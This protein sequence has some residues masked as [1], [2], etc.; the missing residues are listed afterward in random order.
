M[1]PV[2]PRAGQLQRAS[3][4]IERKL[5]RL[6]LACTVPA[7]LALLVLMLLQYR[8][9]VDS[10]RQRALGL[11]VTMSAALDS[12]LLEV[13]AGLTGL[14][15]ASSLLDRDLVR[16]DER[17]RAFQTVMGTGPLVLLDE[18][19][20]QL[21]NTR[22]PQGAE[23]PALGSDAPAMSVIRSGR[24][25]A[26][27]T[28]SAL[29]GEPIAIIAIPVL[30]GQGRRY[31]LGVRVD[32]DRFERLLLTPKLPPSW[33]SAIVDAEGKI[34]ARSVQAKTFVGKPAAPSLQAALANKSVD[35]GAFEG[36]TLEGIPV[37]TVYSRTPSAGWTVVIGIPRADLTG[38]LRDK[39]ALLLVMTLALLAFAYRL[40]W[41][42]GQRIA[43]S[44]AALVSAS[45]DLGH[46]RLVQLP[47][48]HFDEAEQVGAAM[49]HASIVLRE[50]HN[51]LASK[52]AR[53]RAVLDTA[54]DGIVVVD[55][56]QKIVS[57]NP[58]ASR[59]F[60]HELEEALGMPLE[61]LVPQSA[62]G[63]HASMVERYGAEPTPKPRLMGGGRTLHGVRRD[64]SEFPIEVSIS[65]VLVEGQQFYT[66]IVRDITER[67]RTHDTLLR[68]NIELQQFA[69]V[70]S[71]DMRTPLRSILGFLSILAKSHSSRLEPRGLDLLARASRAAEQ[72]DHLTVD[73]LAYARLERERRSEDPVH[74]EEVLATCRL[75]LTSEIEA[76]NARIESGPLPIIIGSAPEVSQLLQNLI[77]N[78]IKYR[79]AGR[80]PV[81]KICCVRKG[82][83][84]WHL[85]V[86]DNG[87]G[88]EPQYKDQV[89]QIFKR[90]HT[91]EA[92]Q[93]SGIGLAVCRKIVERHGG[94]IWVESVPGM[95][96]TFHFTLHDSKAP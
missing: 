25:M 81:V 35:S 42:G 94:R 66:V 86:T 58:A 48:L 2:A 37:I 75:L 20:R 27:L 76:T 29:R 78:A 18:T 57:F 12:Y 5:R 95:G 40:A 39:L 55:A 77:G 64:G 59:L 51:D 96:S 26:K 30:D 32:F 16:F 83:D 67:L 68:S 53:W 31:S 92:I 65:S 84:A 45:V 7:F 91:H 70:A 22:L 19:G 61:M 49:V 85:T 13:Q 38:D 33:I 56:A 36:T 41:R 24:P 63:G 50:A 72:L 14:A 34:V 15:M 69:F 44:A 93:G 1:R 62:R 3:P 6:V 28:Q 89:F 79:A 11:S 9:D 52:E 71:H 8:E 23:L 4:R 10:A 17:A 73:L 80:D 60:G 54:M 43:D 87:I 88:I 21:V 90:L 47:P 46:G 82:R 74:L